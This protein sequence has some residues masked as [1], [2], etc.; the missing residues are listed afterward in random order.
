MLLWLHALSMNKGESLTSYFPC[1]F[2]KSDANMLLIGVIGSKKFLN[3]T[4]YDACH[5]HKA[6]LISFSLL[7]LQA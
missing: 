6:V 2:P 5:L 4:D 7:L 1:N 3:E